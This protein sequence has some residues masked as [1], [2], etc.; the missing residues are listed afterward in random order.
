MADDIFLT[1]EEQDERAR[2]WLKDNGPALIIGIL[3]GLGGIFGWE[4]YKASQ[5][6]NAQQ[7]SALYE[8]VLE[9][10]GDSEL[11]DFDAQLNK[12]KES[13]A[14]TSYAAKASL[15]KARQLAVTDLDGASEQLQWVID[16]APESGLK[17]TARIRLA[18]IK[19]SQGDLDTAAQLASVE[20]Q[21][22]FESH[23]A[24]I[25]AEVAI[26]RG[27]N[28]L[29]RQELQT[30]ID[31]LTQSQASYARVLTIKLDRLPVSEESSKELSKE[32]SIEPSEVASETAAAVEQNEAVDEAASASAT[33]EASAE[34]ETND[35]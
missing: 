1:Q 14:G 7:A 32:L 16:N 35:Q 21:L 33:D 31:K 26:E 9:E 19:L 3:L 15:I 10:Y 22:S 5:E 13:Y 34:A 29:A 24:E 4:Q 20:P 23:Y 2:K 25:R 30:A 11:S 17:H 28:E 18:K 8:Q 6:S 12:L 27:D